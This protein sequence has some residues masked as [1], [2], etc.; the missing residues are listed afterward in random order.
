MAADIVCPR[1]GHANTFI[2]G[3]LID[4]CVCRVC[5]SQL[6]WREIPGMGP[7][8]RPLPASEESGGRSSESAGDAE[9]A[10]A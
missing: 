3:Y 2:K 6:D 9:K 1:C 8:C 10:G 5:Q 4:T 7:D